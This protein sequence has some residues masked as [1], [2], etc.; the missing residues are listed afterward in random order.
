[1]KPMGVKLHNYAWM[2]DHANANAVYEAV[3]TGQMPPGA[4]WH[5]TKVNLFA[6]WMSDG[7]KP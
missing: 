4:S 5:A 2:S 1:M 7:F 3:K 6:K